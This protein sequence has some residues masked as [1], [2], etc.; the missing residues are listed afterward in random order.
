LPRGIR[1]FR[2]GEAARDQTPLAPLGKGGKESDEGWE[3]LHRQVAEQFRRNLVDAE[4]W[5]EACRLYF[6]YK[7]GRLTRSELGRRLADTKARFDPRAG[8]GLIAH[9]FDRFIEEW[10]RVYAGNLMRRSMEGL[11]RS[12]NGEPF[13]P[14]LKAEEKDE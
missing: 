13:L 8:T 7:A 5:Y 9:T 2:V 14:G 12:P 11:H 1:G 3:E 10:E 6:D 4:L